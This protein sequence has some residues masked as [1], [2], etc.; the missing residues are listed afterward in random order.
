M[1]DKTNIEWAD[2]TFNP[3]I[4]CTKVSSA[5]DNCYAENMMDQ[6]MHIVKWGAGQP[7]KRTSAANWQKPL[8]WNKQPFVE[9]ASCGWRGEL[10]HF[11]HGN[12]PAGAKHCP[13]CFGVD[14]IETRRR[15]FCASLADVFDNEVPTKWR[16]DLFNLIEKTPNIDWLILT[17]RI[18]NAP[19]MIMNAL[20]GM[21][22][23]SNQEPP[24][25]PW[26]NVWLGI[27][28]CN[29][30]EAD[31]DIPKLLQV[32]AA[33]RFLSM[34]PLLGAVDLTGEYLK[35]KLGRY[36]FNSL[37]DE[38]RTKLIQLL[39]WVIVGGESGH[40][41]RP[42]HPDWV[43]GL[44]D[45]CKAAGVPFHF[46]QWGEWAPREE[47]S[48]HAKA[49]CAIKLDGSP[50]SHDDAPQDVGGYRFELVGK[51]AAGRLLDSFE[52]NGMPKGYKP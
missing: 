51:Q 38:H 13:S 48:F 50:V 32:P 34:E 43:R 23:R 40:N 16:A 39:D 35:A 24:I 1:S 22:I 19:S 8:Q 14:Y 4:G 47:W 11:N 9:C 20:Q 37:P 18:G 2:S 7:R 25:W 49:Q 15:V 36:P 27:T 5:C 31:R 10:R 46:K 45:Q 30:A 52:H 28:V 6:R 21:F 26:P 17:K 33:V 44:R 42:M 3:F 12:H 29:Q 41:A